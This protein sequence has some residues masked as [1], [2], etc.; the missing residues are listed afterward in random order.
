MRDATE[1]VLVALK[2]LAGQELRRGGR[3]RIADFVA[4][5]EV[6]W[7]GDVPPVEQAGIRLRS[8]ALELLPRLHLTEQ[9]HA[10]LLVLLGHQEIVPV[11]DPNSEVPWSY[12]RAK[13]PKRIGQRRNDLIEALGL[14]GCSRDDFRKRYENP[15]LVVLAAALTGAR[16]SPPGID[17]QQLGD[18]ETSTGPTPNEDEL[19]VA[20]LNT[21]TR[22]IVE[23]IL[24]KMF[25]PPTK[26]NYRA[27]TPGMSGSSV[28]LV[29]PRRG[30]ARAPCVAKIGPARDIHAELRA[31]GEHVE[32]YLRNK[33]LPGIH[34]SVLVDDVGGIAYKFFADTTLNRRLQ[35][36]AA[37]EDTLA[38]EELV[39][40][41]LTV[42]ISAWN[43][44]HRLPRN[45]VKEDYPLTDGDLIAFESFCDE[46]PAP[47]TLPPED[48]R[49]VRRLWRSE[50]T[51]AHQL[52]CV[53]RCH[54]DLYGENVL[55]DSDDDLCLI[56]FSHADEQH[57]LR[58]FIT[59]EG[60]LLLRLLPAGG[61]D[62]EVDA[63]A[64]RHLVNLASADFPTGFTPDPAQQPKVTAGAAAALRAIRR[65]AWGR[66]EN[67]ADEIPN[68]QVG[69]IRRLVRT[70][71]R[72]ENRLS[73]AQRCAGAL[74]AVSHARSLAQTHSLASAFS[75]GGAGAAP[76]KSASAGRGA[77]V[78][79]GATALAE[80]IKDARSLKA[81]AFS[82]LGGLYLDV[83]LDP[84][85]T[86][87]LRN[88]E[89]SNLEP[90]EL[91]LGGSCVQVG[92]ALYEWFNVQSVLFSAIGGAADPFSAE[93]RRLLARE[94]WIAQVF[95]NDIAGVSTAVS[96][97]LQQGSAE[98]TTIF[99]H[100]GALEHLGW[101][102][103][104]I[105]LLAEHEAGRVLYLAGYFR[106]RLYSG[107][108][109]HLQ[110]MS[111]SQIV[112][113]DHGAL[114]PEVESADSV[115]RLKQAFAR[116][117][118][119]IYIC[120]LGELWSLVKHPQ[121]LSLPPEEERSAELVDELASQ[122]ELPPVTIVRGQEWPGPANAFLVLSSSGYRVEL[123]TVKATRPTFRSGVGLDN[124]FNA[125]FLYSIV[126]GDPHQDVWDAVHVAT[127]EGLKTWLS[128]S[129]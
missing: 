111:R 90:V 108:D 14:H 69:L 98:F 89:W 106:T 126:T 12:Q 116:G 31:W 21:L 83:I 5:S 87:E 70:V 1:A 42:L 29:Y 57:Y 73:H 85:Q 10:I 105:D 60:D 123:V 95:C 16:H 36:L 23:K 30:D 48:V 8:E 17:S 114:V 50:S 75:S 25:P 66:M 121:R 11:A 80:K 122:L 65:H 71:A 124:V 100:K 127:R 104:W 86:T 91:R 112:V 120:T 4:A 46:M 44:K 37:V 119:D 63:K 35:G 79:P 107:L 6:L 3:S 38:I 74:L 52:Q 45:L 84:V 41:L 47:F 53:S 40:K 51:H 93:A 103:Q 24:G 82:L 129:R 68:Y 22:H 99:T 64:A 33:H 43:E 101:R 18:S 2:W 55:V 20:A 77:L 97:H 115:Q 67:N 13:A 15:A 96:V 27:L 26:V 39:S 32:P 9:E 28:F 109:R 7:P 54:G 118:I 88:E 102:E 56:D 59:L 78:P 58:D 72:V 81:P 110:E 76:S 62:V 94:G 19:T 92:R 117:Q 61:A 125:G 34:N 113:I 49:L 128:A